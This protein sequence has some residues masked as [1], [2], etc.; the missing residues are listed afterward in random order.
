[1]IPT[2][3]KSDCINGINNVRID[4]DLPEP[5]VPVTSVAVSFLKDTGSFDLSSLIAG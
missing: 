3:V 4:A 2:S 1:M 5:I